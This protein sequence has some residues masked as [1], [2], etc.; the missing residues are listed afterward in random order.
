[1]MSPLRGGDARPQLPTF[2]EECTIMEAFRS[3]HILSVHMRNTFYIKIRAGFGSADLFI[4]YKYW[5]TSLCF[6]FFT[7]TTT[8]PFLNQHFLQP[9]LPSLILRRKD[10]N[11]K[12]QNN[13]TNSFCN[14]CLLNDRIGRKWEGVILPMFMNFHP[15]PVLP[16]SELYFHANQNTEFKTMDLGHHTYQASTPLSSTSQ[17][18]RIMKQSSDNPGPQSTL[19]QLIRCHEKLE[20]V[21][22]G[23][24]RSY[25]AKWHP[26][27]R[28]SQSDVGEEGAK[29]Y[30][31]PPHGE[32]MP[33]SLEQ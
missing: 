26:E 31:M 30:S 2:Q 29:N 27:M 33:G 17:C 7:T 4:E 24:A 8:S 18:L 5:L 28:S 22:S 3:L 19:I 13:T 1:M 16:K 32:R 12:D 15:G 11:Q 21:L 25:R 14:L 6:P 10:A 23:K 9:M 20:D